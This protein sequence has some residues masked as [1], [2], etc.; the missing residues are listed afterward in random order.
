VGDALRL[1]AVHDFSPGHD[2]AYAVSE[3]QAQAV[4]EPAGWAQLLA[5][6]SLLLAWHGL[7]ARR[8]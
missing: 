7:A 8:R 5:G 3:I 1:S 4:P 6:M 2:Y